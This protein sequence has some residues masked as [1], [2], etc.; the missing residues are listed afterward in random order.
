MYLSIALALLLK[1]DIRNLSSFIT[2]LL[3]G[4]L[5]LV[6]KLGSSESF[7]FQHWG[8][9]KQPSVYTTGVNEQQIMSCARLG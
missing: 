8:P 1:I 2:R 7:K 4:Y 9:M 5:K 6:R 3:P